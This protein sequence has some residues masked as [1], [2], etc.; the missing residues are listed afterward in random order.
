MSDKAVWWPRLCG[1]CPG[2]PRLLLSSILSWQLLVLSASWLQQAHTLSSFPHAALITSKLMW[3]V[4]QPYR[5]DLSHAT[6]RLQFT[7]MLSLRE[8]SSVATWCFWWH[9]RPGSP[10][11]VPCWTGQTY[12]YIPHLSQPQI[13]WLHCIVQFVFMSCTAYPSSI[14]LTL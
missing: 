13:S 3:H 10:S 9:C 11:H 12:I 4:K 2:V 6:S 7:V 8:I 1:D 14:E 5:L